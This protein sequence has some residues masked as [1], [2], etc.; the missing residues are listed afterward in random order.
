MSSSFMHTFNVKSLFLMNSDHM[1][2]YEDHKVFKCN[3]CDKSFSHLD[4]LRSHIKTIHEGHKDSKFFFLCHEYLL[5][6]C[7]SDY[8]MVFHFFVLCCVYY[9]Y[10]FEDSILRIFLSIMNSNMFLQISCFKKSCRM[11]H[12]CNLFVHYELYY[13]SSNFLV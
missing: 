1:N 7:L 11:Y 2:I 9:P 6:I 8:Y 4:A 5:S 10:A 3:S 13:V 12:I